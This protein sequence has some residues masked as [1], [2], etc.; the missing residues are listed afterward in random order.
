MEFR[1][2]F[3]LAAN[4]GFLEDYFL[5]FL[6]ELS[7]QLLHGFISFNFALLL[8]RTATVFE[9]VDVHHD[10]LAVLVDV[11]LEL[12]ELA[13]NVDFLAVCHLG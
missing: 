9:L 5:A 1:G 2:G 8:A 7:K 4:K 3:R 11:P 13:Y 12:L 10:V 6:F